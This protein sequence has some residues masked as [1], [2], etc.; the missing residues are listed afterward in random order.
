LAGGIAL[1]DADIG[2][3]GLAGS[4]AYTAS[5]GLWS[6]KGGGSD[7]WNSSDQFNFAAE[8]LRGD[9]AV[10][11]QVGSQ[12]NSNAWA[13]AGVM[14]RN[15]STAGAA[16]ADVV[17]TP[18]NSVL[19]QYRASSGA[20]AISAATA[21]GIVT[22]PI[23][24]KL[25]RVGNS[26]AASYSYDGV[27][28]VQIGDSQAIGMNAVAQA[29]LAVCAVNNAALCTASFSN[30]SVAPS[31]WSDADIGSPGIPGFVNTDGSTITI[32]GSGSDIYN[33]SD[34]F[35]FASQGYVGDVAIVAK[36]NSQ[37]ATG[38]YAKAGVMI[39]D[40]SAANAGYAFMFVNPGATSAGQGANFE[41]RNGT[42][43]AAH[44]ANSAAGITAPY[45]IKLV[46]LGNSF[47]A[48]DSPDGA[49]WTQDG[50]SETI[51]MNPTVQVGL[52]VDG[53]SNSVLNTAAFTHV[54]VTPP[55]WSDND[56]GSPG[57][58]GAATYDGL[59]WSVT[60]GGSDIWAAS[61]Q[62]NFA[63]E[64]YTGDLS[65]IAKVNTQDN[66][67]G[68]AKAGVM[69]RD[70]LAA[71][72]AYVSVFLTPSNGLL[73]ESRSA[74]GASSQ[75]TSG[76]AGVAA[77]YWVKLVRSGNV[78]TGYYSA[79]GA[80]W[81]QAG[82]GVLVAMGPTIQ[83]GLAVDAN[84]NAALSAV[85][86]SNVQAGAQTTDPFLKA[87]GQNFRNGHGTGD[88]VPLHGSNLG[89]WL[90]QEP[91]INNI[92]SSGLTTD[93][94]VWNTL[95]SRFGVATS[96]RLM[97]EFQDNWI[98]TQDLDNV[99]AMG[100]N[101]L[102]VP[103]SYRILV[104]SSGNWR[105]DAFTK[106][107]WA[108]NEA[109]KRGI[110]TILDFHGLPGGDSPFASSGTTN[111]GAFWT[112]TANQDLAASIWLRVAQHFAGNPGVAAYDL[113]NEPVVSSTSTLW[114]VYNRLYW[115]VRGAD[116]D[117]IVMME[118]G[119]IG[120]SYWNLDTLPNPI[121]W[122]WTNVAYQTHAYDTNGGSGA[123]G[124]AN[125]QVGEFQQRA[126]YNVPELVGEFNLG[127]QD[128]YGVQLWN[129]NNMSWTTWTFKMK[130]SMGGNWGIYDVSGQW[131]W[132]PNVQTDSS[133]TIL[134]AYTNANTAGRWS[135]NP[136][137]RNVVGSAVPAADSY[138]TTPANPL[139]V[140]PAGG[141][142]A[143]DV[144]PNAGQS[145]I[146]L[147]AILVSNVSHGA[148]TLYADGSFYYVPAAGFAG[149][150]T[151]RYLVYDGNNNSS[152]VSTVSIAVRPNALPSK[153]SDAD[154]G[155]PNPT[156]WA[157]Y[158]GSSGTWSVAGGGADIWNT[159]DQFNFAS[160]SATGDFSIVARIG[161][162]SGTAD[163]AKAGLMIRD[164]TSAG[165]AY[166]FAFLTPNNGKAG[167]GANFEFRPSAGAAS[168]GGGSVAGITAPQ[169]LKLSR[170]GNTFTAY[171]S[172]NGTTWSQLGFTQTIA[173][174]ATL[175]IGLAVDANSGTA[176][177]AATFTN[178]SVQSSVVG[179]YVFYNNSVYDGNDP[180]ATAA[181]DNAIAPDKSALLPGQTATFANYTNYARGLNGMMIDIANLPTAN[182][183]ASDFTLK[184]GTS[185]NP[186][187][188]LSAP[189]PSITVRPGAG[190]NGSDRVELVWPDQAILNQ[191]L[192]V[193][194]NATAN[195]GLAAP[196]VFYFG[197]LPGDTGNAPAGSAN[198]IVSVADI[199]TVKS[200][201]GLTASITSAFD[202]NRD[203]RISI[204]DI[205]LAKSENG[206]S[207]P[208]LA[209]PA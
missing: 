132:T 12:S 121:D 103:F 142:L 112:N 97:A 203:G 171:Y 148:L 9:G 168:Q 127:D 24:V 105:S 98:T 53:F 194:V 193:T 67:G 141:V 59:T 29:G 41:Y 30:F 109:W 26:F 120:S 27:N 163:Y 77:P 195:T 177:N 184:T 7:I 200:Q 172:S 115:T 175:S 95:Q 36:I 99:R 70:G 180:T 86:F 154:I 23:W 61:D 162:M 113:L 174:S 62:F 155:P 17:V 75:D 147:Q 11:T 93:V 71:N 118:G 182:L 21:G 6:I 81:T 128:R 64:S 44:S 54:S 96:N 1:T 68:Y 43:T 55:G 42:G 10:I 87:N 187:T 165:A 190:V 152:T 129:Q 84:N 92:D 57:L 157:S 125:G 82:Q 122:N 16:F 45:W 38:T 85:T 196:D 107:D 150:D 22:A 5:T 90:L 192:Q 207:L 39:R 158:D 19:F 14:I 161:G 164:G 202:F 80:S 135:I 138:S 176:V 209:A 169:W 72:A 123:Q 32:G 63:S 208:L 34:Q 198:A 94:D 130:E 199:L 52:A 137:L 191:W 126:Y 179:R 18:S 49:T 124:V 133:A 88:A 104:D 51:A 186:T 139:Y 56:I 48:F 173:M 66:T 201:N 206:I 178:V 102:R 28:W 181:D 197:N 149:T 151:F 114:S 136:V 47:T 60:G 116:A 79:D 131:P 160:R 110:Y 83:A 156:G 15:D 159:A 101:V 25:G 58:S 69:I 40:G 73:F 46:R 189:A 117:H 8:S 91:W 166:A 108:V 119:G 188:W 3:P 2:A 35:N 167:E 204:S 205:L 134:S 33:S 20:A 146:S 100:L 183:L 76:V 111:G 145:G 78:F 153:W 143:N 106:L 185:A 31:G 50:P 144:D 74:A 89:G 65:V 37:T 170:A 4:A 140:A 13:K